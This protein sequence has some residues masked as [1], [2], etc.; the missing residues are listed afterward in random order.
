MIFNMK[1]QILLRALTLAL[2][3]SALFFTG[4][5]TPEQRISDHPDI[6]QRLSARDQELVKVGK[7]REGMGQDA[8]YLAWGTP[9]QKG[10]GVAHGRSVETWVYNDYYNASSSYP[11]PY[12]P[13]GYGGYFGGGAVFHRHHGHNYA[14]IGNPWYDP[15]YYSYIPPRVAYPA[16]TVTF[17]GGRVV[18]I[19]V[20]TEPR[21]RY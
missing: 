19:Q 15:F 11:Y 13:Y 8:V 5:A 4:C 9:D 17:S 18:G 3:A 20:L 1:R 6:F 12:G 7:I 10:T 21:Y 16:K 14:I 2:S